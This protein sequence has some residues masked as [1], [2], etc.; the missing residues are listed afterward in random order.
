[1]NTLSKLS[2]RKTSR[3]IDYGNISTSHLDYYG[4]RFYDTKDLF[5]LDDPLES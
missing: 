4:K 2:D 5:E 3:A 1:M